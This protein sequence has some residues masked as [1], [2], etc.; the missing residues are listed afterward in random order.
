VFLLGTNPV[1]ASGRATLDLTVPS[2]L[3]GTFWLQGA[4]LSG[5]NSATSSAVSMTVLPPATDSV[6]YVGGAGEQWLRDAVQLSDGTVLLAGG[7]TDLSWAAGVPTT[8]L[9]LP[10]GMNTVSAG[11]TAFLLHVSADL[12]TPLHL[13]TWPADTFRDVARLRTTNVP[14]QPT[15]E[16]YVSLTRDTASWQGDGYAIARLDGNFVDDVPTAVEM[17]YE[18][19]AEPR[20][21]GGRTGES[22]YKT[23]Q[24]WDVDASGNVVFGR[25]A[26][27]DFNW[28]IVEKIDRDGNRMV[29]PGWPAHWVDIGGEFRGHADDFTG[30]GVLTHSGIVMKAGRAGSL[31][32]VTQADYD[33]VQSDGNGRTDRP[34]KWPDDYFFSGPCDANCPGGP[35]YTGYRVSSKPTQRVGGIVI[36]RRNGDLYFGYST[37]SVLPG[38]N[39]DFEPAM[40]AFDDDGNLRWWNRLYEETG[41]NSS[42]DQYVDDLAFDYANDRVVVLAR[43]HGNNTVNLWRGNDI[44]AR[45]GASGFQNQFTGTSGNIHISWL[46]SFDLDG[47]LHASTYVAEIGNTPSGVTGTLSDPNLDGWHNPN[48]GWPD[49]NTTRCEAGIDVDPQGRVAIACT[50]RRTITTHDA[51]QTMLQAS[52][53]ESKWNEFVR[54]YTPDLDDV[55]YSTLLTG[56]WDPADPGAPNETELG[57]VFALADGFLATGWHTAT[58]GVADGEPVPT[59]GVPPWGLTAPTNRTGVLARL[60]VP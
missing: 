12:S 42:P 46:G 56:T 35:G 4:A 32:S 59:G 41:S 60:S 44:A 22:A 57:G 36:D 19:V 33:L 51:W 15:G 9:G 54:V 6:F 7:A 18:V 48:A 14:G 27:Y 28:A 29:V 49:L 13:V 20:S 5:G 58:N 31:R 50:G 39:P 8:A 26:E 23:I 11:N 47:E 55:V 24:P 40:V 37:Q 43:A 2:T 3:S 34:G 30:P 21:A 17:A 53:G 45:P 1:D 10:A 38:G 16:L 52:E 25:G